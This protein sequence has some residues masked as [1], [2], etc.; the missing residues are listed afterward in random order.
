MSLTTPSLRL[1]WCALL[2][3]LLVVPTWCVPDPTITSVTPN[4]AAPVGEV[5]T[6]TVIGTNYQIFANLALMRAG[7]DP[8]SPLWVDQT[9]GN[10]TRLVAHFSFANV[11]PGR[12]DVLVYNQDGTSC[13]LPIG[14]Q[15][16]KPVE[17]QGPVH[18]T[19]VEYRPTRATD[20]PN[21]LTN[22]DAAIGSFSGWTLIRLGGNFSTVR[23]EG[24]NP[25]FALSAQAMS[26]RV[27]LRTAGYSTDEL[28]AGR[29]AR[30]AFRF[31]GDGNSTPSAFKVTLTFERENGTAVGTQSFEKTATRGTWETVAQD[32]VLPA[33]T[34]ALS[35]RIDWLRGV[36]AYSGGA[37]MSA[38]ALLDDLALSLVNP[39]Y[40]VVAHAVTGPARVAV[41]SQHAAVTL[42]TTAGLMVTAGALGTPRVSLE[43]TIEAMNAALA[44]LAFT[45]A[46]YVG[47]DTVTL[48]VTDL[49]TGHSDT[50]T[51]TLTVTPG[52]APAVTACTPVQ[53]TPR[54][55]T[56]TVTGVNFR[57][58][59]AV[60][61]VKAGQPDLPATEV[62]ASGAEQLTCT[63]DL[64]GQAL[65]AWTVVVTNPDG[66]ASTSVSTLTLVK[67]ML[68]QGPSRWTLLENQ[69]TD[70]VAGRNLLTNPNAETGSFSGWTLTDLGGTGSTVVQSGGN[71]YFR[72]TR[73]AMSQW[74]NLGTSFSAVDLDARPRVR[75]TCRC[76]GNGNNPPSAFKLTFFFVGN[77]G[78]SLGSQSFEQ[79]T[80]RGTWTTVA[81]EFEVPVST[82]AV[83]VR[84][85]WLRGTY[86]S[87]ATTETYAPVL[88][89]DLSL[90]VLPA[91][92]QVAPVLGTGPVRVALASQHAAVSLGTTTGVTVAAGALGTPQVTL[93]GTLEAVNAALAT[94]TLTVADYFGTDPLTATV[95]DVP[96]GITDP[97]TTT[98]T[99]TPAPAP[100]VTACAPAQVAPLP[101]TVTL[102]GSGF[103]PNVSVKLMKAGQPDLPAT[104]VVATDAEHLTCTWDLTGQALGAWT[105]VVTNPD[106]RAST[107]AATLTLT[108]PMLMH[109]PSRWTLRENQTC[110]LVD[111][112]NLLTNADAGTGAFSGWTLIKLGGNFSTV[113]QE[114]GNP[115]FALA[116]QAMSQR[117]NLLTAGYTPELLDAGLLARLAFRCSG[118]GNTTPSAFKVTLTFERENGTAVGTQSFEKTATRGTWETVAQDF[119]LPAGARALTLRIDWL[120][121][122]Y[123]YSGGAVMSAPALLDDLTLGVTPPPFQVVAK[124]GAGPVRVALASQHAA[125]TL[126]TMTGVTVAAG[127]LGTSQ[128]TL[129]GTVEAV[130]AALATLAFTVEGYAG[131]DPLTATV[132]DV[133]T[134][135]SDSVTAH[136]TVL[137]SQPDLTIITPDL[138]VRAPAV[139]LTLAGNRFN[140]GA[141]VK[142]T[143]AGQ[144]D[145][146]AGNVSIANATSLTCTFDL[147]QTAP[148]VWTV[149]V[150]NVNGLSS[151]QPVTL[152]V[153]ERAATVQA[154]AAVT[155]AESAGDPAHGLTT[156]S[157]ADAFP[158]AT[159]RVSLA[160]NQVKM[161]LGQ[162]TGVAI[163]AGE[164][165]STALIFEGPL[166]AVNAA[167]ASLKLGIVDFFGVDTLTVTVEDL[168]HG[169]PTDTK[170]IAITVTALP[171]PTLTEVTPTTFANDADVALT[172]TGTNFRDGARVRLIRSRNG[173]VQAT[174][175]TVTSSTRLTCVLNMV[176]NTPGTWMVAVVNPNGRAS[177]A[178]AVTLTNRPIALPDAY[179]T[180]TGMPLTISAPGVLS[181]DTDAFSTITAAQSVLPPSHGSATL[182]STGAFTYTPAAGFVGV[183]SFTYRVKNEASIYS[184]TATV[185]ITVLPVNLAPTFTA[186]STASVAEY[187]ELLFGPTGATAIALADADAATAP[188]QLTLAA[189][190]ALTLA[191][192]TG[193][194]VTA[195]A[196]GTGALTVRGPVAAL[197]A[198]LAGMRYRCDDWFG[199]DTLT[200]TV[201]DLG[202]SGYGGA[203][204]A[205]KAIT[206]TVTRGALPTVTAVTPVR[207]AGIATLTLT[208]TTLRPNATIRLQK[209]GQP[210][211]PATNVTA[212]DGTHLTCTVNLNG[213]ALGDWTVVV[214]NPDGLVSTAGV[215]FTV[216]KPLELQVPSLLA[217][218]EY[219]S[220][221]PTD[222][223]NLLLNPDA[224]GGSFSD[225]TLLRLSGNFSEVRR[226][227]GNAVFALAGQAMTQQ[228]NLTA[229]GY[230]AGALDGGNQATLAF[231]FSGDGNTIQSKYKVTLTFAN[232]GGAA[233]GTQSFERTATRGVWETVQQSYPLP[234]G[235]RTLTVR[236]DW[237]A[238]RYSVPGLLNF[239]AAALL[240]DF[241][242]SLMPTLYQVTRYVGEGPVRVEVST[243]RSMISLGLPDGV[244]VSAGALGTPRVVVEGEIAAVNAAL[245]S[246]AFTCTDYIGTDTA[247]CTVTDLAT[248]SIDT[249]TTPLTITRG[250]AP[251]V[252]SITPA[253][254]IATVTQLSLTGSTLRPNAIVK[255]KKSGQADIVATDV[256]VHEA[257]RLTCA[258]DMTGKA[259]GDWTVMVTNPDGQ[260]NSSGTIL[261]VGKPVVLGKPAVLV[262]PEYQPGRPAD[263]GN[264]LVNPDAEGGS[265]SDWT[266][267]RL[268]GNFSEVRRENGNAVFAL[269]G[270]AMTQ[271]VN[272]TA[273]GY[274]AGALDGGNQATLA[275]RFSG[276]GNTIQSKFKVTL[277][278]ATAAG[279]ALGTQSF[280]RTATRGVWETVQQ[281]YPLP[282]GMRTLTVRLDWLAGRYSVPGLLNFSAAA[283]LDDFSL[284]LTPTPYQVTR[285]VG[286]GPVRVEVSTTRATI[287]FGS[288]AGVTVAAGAQGTTR[289][290]IEGEIAAVN[291][292]LAS[293]A[294]SCPDYFGADTATC[295]VTDLPTGIADSGTTNLT[296]TRGQLPVVS[297]ITPGTGDN[298]SSGIA[299]TLVG[300]RFRPGAT[301]TLVKT[302]QPDI[303][304]TGVT[305]PSETQLTGIFDI[306][307]K[308]P[309]A[310]TVVVRNPDGQASAGATFTIV[311]R[312]V[313]VGESFSTLEDTP[314]ARPAPGVLGND[315]SVLPLTATLV[316]MPAYGT[317]TLAATGGFTYTPA[318]DWFG[319]DSFTYRASDGEQATE[320]VTVTLTVMA[321]N[322]PPRAHNL[323]LTATAGAGA[324]VT[325]E[326]SDV[327]GETGTLGYVIITNPAHGTLSGTAPHL[328]Y[329]ATTGYVGADS[330]EYKVTDGA[331]DSP[332]ARVAITV[333]APRLT[334]VQL[335][336]RP[337]AA[338][339]EAKS[340]IVLYP[341]PQGGANVRYRYETSR[342]NGQS[343]QALTGYI[344]GAQY[345]WRPSTAG[346]Y[347]VRVSACNGGDPATGVQTSNVLT[348][349]ITPERLRVQL[350][351]DKSSP[352]FKSDIRLT[353][354]VTGGTNPLCRFL[355]TYTRSGRQVTQV[356]QGY[357]S[358]RSCVWRPPFT[359]TNYT[360]IVEV[361]D[362]GSTN[363]H[364]DR[365]QTSF[366]ILF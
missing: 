157:I 43:G 230:P 137:P 65:G 53:I 304:A 110:L 144:A 246:L 356:L 104:S 195:G 286:T 216:V 153:V 219:Q 258:V 58:N 296:I 250:P 265:F 49:P 165:K 17:L 264:L 67:P 40:Q 253:R 365:S 225:W 4:M 366:Y 341:T 88:L 184:A 125:V 317:V 158:T 294:F 303:V 273:L 314:L 68:M 269:A 191:T 183:D 142:L 148:G 9:E 248:G 139:T 189:R 20:G 105:V 243:T 103:R 275:F 134:G 155:I 180:G 345:I 26:Q 38:P 47:P 151:T 164:Q 46:D 154:P 306:V 62:I 159:V 178:R 193:L 51:T 256:V 73:Q 322:D 130:N 121:G 289:V 132:T 346:T 129:A 283:L 308:T 174:A 111:S 318:T 66:Q 160:T 276:D 328:T 131:D 235:T 31:S 76:S 2:L 260:A 15:I 120:R 211:I 18:N 172:L 251:A 232:A 231:R 85:D 13:R 316:T 171:A 29:Q 22:P 60:K 218:P 89:D 106:G 287:G 348:C 233:L 319:T 325:L 108:M 221:R 61:L 116:G 28:D 141:T 98:L 268:S 354:Q 351:T 223:G 36:Y 45:V 335:E 194:T 323:S 244:T 55:N 336:I 290:A 99:V 162:T 209:T 212:P 274:P 281:S 255:L 188:V 34:R 113:R 57:P 240:D 200:C 363:A 217:F 94:L 329:T 330:F 7:F 337:A 128:V 166:A 123:A 8:V 192:L 353:A 11:A 252:S 190:G 241:S 263:G 310:W 150:T 77:L 187:A 87:G 35:V 119:V 257:T 266:L 112:R 227:S 90:A 5:T 206:V 41:A 173:E 282:A 25:V 19:Q 95:T 226:E 50:L 6:V 100:T 249:G 242:L 280:E 63:W 222:G 97:L 161:L 21:L 117:V 340:S 247:T 101:T 210:D 333:V 261:T 339:Y 203:K 70:F 168:T 302:G 93:E 236:L 279:A 23:Q 361:K 320:P 79:T 109:G 326:G 127:A 182:N 245:A 196:N 313:A 133:P 300:I 285:N 102:T 91:P 201:N 271:S 126:S 277:T 311:N 107:S 334:G 32:Y 74:V 96:T 349:T 307:G 30:V 204:S 69:P 364:D 177:L 181:N 84:I 267:L 152:T 315:T 344:E 1:A 362:A 309:G 197:N 44:T 71:P 215:I 207:G 228:V 238:G 259:L 37:V 224:E 343:W 359:F 64:T 292:A 291:T 167:L 175:V 298:T 169:G 145:I 355:V 293:L 135:L 176:G 342:D 297:S 305:I 14:F 136:F 202:N 199:T 352:A 213:K 33:G 16:L 220:G 179:Q 301:L 54:L 75:F 170:T 338:S 295:T 312:P 254:A 48:T 24:G 143:Q 288:I 239:S 237:L 229:L 42:G 205:T 331:L 59:A 122:V 138:V 10:T 270:Q 327:P 147:A 114:G 214:A 321:V 140:A 163:T 12:W 324:A 347:R 146:I 3:G 262:F 118:D 234:A 56:V 124:I 284:S 80:T 86:I 350:Q 149:V 360:L 115:V 299:A 357:S 186:P 27:D 358:L 272:L 208:G 198:A 332:S 92:F 78:G 82:R 52:P 156:L 185:T 83:T 81:R 278:F 72:L 39:P